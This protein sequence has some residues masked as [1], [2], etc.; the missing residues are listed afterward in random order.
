MIKA[1]REIDQEGLH[2]HGVMFQVEGN[3]DLRTCLGRRAVSILGIA[4]WR[5]FFCIRLTGNVITSNITM[6]MFTKFLTLLTRAVHRLPP[7]MSSSART[8]G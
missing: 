7:D 2:G 4:I 3:T 1:T 6:I 8:W 5:V